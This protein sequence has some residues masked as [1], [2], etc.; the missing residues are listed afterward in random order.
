MRLFHARQL[1][2]ARG[3][4]VNAS[5]GPERDVAQRSRLHI[6]M[7]DRRLQQAPVALASAEDYYNYGIALMNSRSVGAA[8]EHLEI[9][10][11]MAPAADHILYALGVAQALEGNFLAAHENLKR[12]I[13]MEPRN[14]IIARQDADLAH[15]ANQPP[16][17][18]LLFPE[19]KVW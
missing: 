15:L 19:K 16:F 6:A 13:E 12:A 7:C 2:D 1:K 9:A 10:L 8:R 18:T 5:E 14:R 17:D 4:F 11:R 3:Y